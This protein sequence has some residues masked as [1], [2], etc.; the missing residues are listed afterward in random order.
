MKVRSLILALLLSVVAANEAE[1]GADG[2]I[3]DAACDCASA[4]AEAVSAVA[5]EK[6]GLLAELNA[7]REQANAKIAEVDNLVGDVAVPSISVPEWPWPSNRHWH[8]A[9]ESRDIV[10]PIQ[11]RQ[12][13]FGDR[14]ALLAPLDRFGPIED[15]SDRRRPNRLV[16]AGLASGPCGIPRRVLD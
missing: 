6:E 4:V 13:R 9:N 8:A 10:L 14:E 3:N 5:R 11:S 2:T 7:S 15:V 12:G 16:C 1:V